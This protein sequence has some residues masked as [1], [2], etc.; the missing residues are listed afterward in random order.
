M[1]T[2]SQTG[3]TR[4]TLRIT[5]PVLI[6]RFEPG[7][8]AFAADMSQHW[9]PTW[10]P[11]NLTMEPDTAQMTEAHNVAGD[12][13]IENGGGMKRSLP[14]DEDSA[15][16]QTKKSRTDGQ[17]QNRQKQ[18]SLG[19]LQQSFGRFLEKCH[20]WE[21]RR[22]RDTEKMRVDAQTNMHVQD[23]SYQLDLKQQQIDQAEF[24]CGLLRE[25]IAALGHE[26]ATQK[27]EYEAQIEELQRELGDRDFRLDRFE[28]AREAMNEVIDE[29]EGEIEIE[30]EDEGEDE[31]ED[32]GEDE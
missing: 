22:R 5:P 26:A 27:A 12:V 28:R 9:H 25:K 31:D 8:R 6:L 19:D 30:D 2:R 32:E 18:V 13:K 20:Q 15:D 29:D 4:S 21:E 24:E 10:N 7:S 14:D 1:Q 17:T 3:S 16:P 11:Y 23:T